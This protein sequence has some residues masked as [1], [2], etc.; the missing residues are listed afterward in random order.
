MSKVTTYYLHVKDVMRNHNI[1]LIYLTKKEL[2]EAYTRYKNNTDYEVLSIHSVCVSTDII[3]PDELLRI[4]DLK[5]E[6][7]Y[8]YS[9][10]KQRKS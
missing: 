6:G 7:R 3:T 10:S 4:C 2:C 9:T 5:Q 8:G 1:S